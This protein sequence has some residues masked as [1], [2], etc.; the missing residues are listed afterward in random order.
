MPVARGDLGVLG[1]EWTPN[2]GIRVGLQAF[3]RCMSGLLLVAPSEGGPFSAG[4]F[5]TGAGSARG[6]SLE[7]VLSAARYGLLLSYG[8]Q[9]VR[10]RGGEV[11]YIPRHGAQHL[12]DAGVVLFPTA[13]SLIRVSASAGL[14]RRT[15]A[16]GGAFEWE[17]C[18]LLDRGCEFAGTPFLD[19]PLGGQHLP[20]YVR[21]DLGARKHW[22]VDVG[23]R[24]AVIGVYGT[25]TN[26]LG[27]SNVLT[28]ILDPVTGGRRRIDMRP[29]SP[30]VVGV[31][32]RF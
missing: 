7:T 18:N 23:R 17:A 10:L 27:R 9:N 13:T 24:D 20:S 1:L 5:E 8:W 26:V 14:G 30:L 12:I 15:S 28:D 19:G 16:S 31:D 2:A 6:I 25:V 22:H 4:S 11:R 32:W 3:S 21:M 29:P